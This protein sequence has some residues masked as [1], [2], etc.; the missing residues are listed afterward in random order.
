MSFASRGAVIGVAG[1]ATIGVH[2]HFSPDG[3][4][5]NDAFLVAFCFAGAAVGFTRY[6]SPG[7]THPLFV[8]AGLLA[9]ARADRHLRPATGSC[10]TRPTVGRA[11]RS[12]RSDGSSAGWSPAAAFVLARPWWDRRGRAG[13]LRGS[14]CS[15][16]AATLAV[17]DVILIVFRHS[18]PHAKNVDL[19]RDA[20]FA[21]T[22][23]ALL[24]R[25]AHRPRAARHRRVE[26]V[27]SAGRHPHA[28]PV[29]GRGVA[30]RDRRRRWR[31]SPVPSRTGRS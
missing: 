11:S 4:A 24:G 16:T 13:S 12:P 19:R 20:A 3:R 31:C 1:M 8:G 17:P 10:P 7:D 6:R 30:D 29:A 15:V 26:G 14:S 18:L 25:R 21:L 9:V 27:A 5:A 2:A 28:A 22:S 23:P